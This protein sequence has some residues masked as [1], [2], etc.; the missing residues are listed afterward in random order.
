MNQRFEKTNQTNIRLLLICPIQIRQSFL[1]ISQLVST[2]GI[3]Y[4]S[5]K[6]LIFPNHFNNFFL[7]F[8]KDNGAMTP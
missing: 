5:A 6:K 7:S 3:A 4:R 1:D 2:P 8:D